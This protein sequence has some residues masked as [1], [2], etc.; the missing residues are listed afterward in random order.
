MKFSV[1]VLSLCLSFLALGSFS[2]CKSNLEI[3]NFSGSDRKLAIN[4]IQIFNE[5]RQAEHG[6]FVAFE[7]SQQMFKEV[8]HELKY[9]IKEKDPPSDSINKL[10]NNKVNTASKFFPR[11][12]Q[13]S[14]TGPVE[15]ETIWRAL[16]DTQLRRSPPTA[17]V[18]VFSKENIN[19]E[20]EQAKVDAYET[21]V[22]RMKEEFERNLKYLREEL[23]RHKNIQDTLKEV[24]AIEEEIKKMKK[25][26]TCLHKVMSK[27]DSTK[28][29]CS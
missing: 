10:N 23:R 7:S 12:V 25:K 11:F 26:K 4:L 1:K 22:L 18:H 27:A 2:T 13:L 20:Y 15:E 16:Y 14:S 28:V 21:T 24:T 3:P 19:Q 9:E 17:N 8:N 29:E 6:F 5:T